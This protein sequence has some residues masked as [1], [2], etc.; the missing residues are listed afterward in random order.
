MNVLKFSFFIGLVFLVGKYYTFTE[1]KG[2]TNREFTL[3]KHYFINEVKLT[4]PEER[5]LISDFMSYSIGT[6]LT[7]RTNVPSISGE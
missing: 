4:D 5:E 7:N 6:D 1:N 3:L 2:D